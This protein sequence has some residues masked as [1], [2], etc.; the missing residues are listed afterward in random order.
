ML[1]STLSLFL[2]VLSQA[3]SSLSGAGEAAGVSVDEASVP[4]A[5]EAVPINAQHTAAADSAAILFI[6]VLIFSLP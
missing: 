3:V 6:E 4:T 1:C 5:P 2:K